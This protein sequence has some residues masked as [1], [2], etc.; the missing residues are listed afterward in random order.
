MTAIS[1]L[2]PGDVVA[3]LSDADAWG[4]QKAVVIG[5]PWPDSDCILVAPIREPGVITTFPPTLYIGTGPGDWR[6]WRLVE[7]AHVQQLTVTLHIEAPGHLPVDRLAADVPAAGS[8]EWADWASDLGD[9]CKVV[10]VDVTVGER[11][12]VPR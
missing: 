8:D 1:D 11:V 5:A 6:K 3:L 12:E 4:E 9:G 10:A 7:R 2:R